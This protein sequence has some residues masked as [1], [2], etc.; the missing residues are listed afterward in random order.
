MT[1]LT[2][3]QLFF[4]TLSAATSGALIALATLILIFDLIVQREP[5]P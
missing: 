3:I 1:D 2:A 4:I 5:K